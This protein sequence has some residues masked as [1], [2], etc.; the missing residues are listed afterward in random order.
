MMD[1]EII[2]LINGGARIYKYKSSLTRMESIK[3]FEITKEQF[4]QLENDIQ[5]LAE[6]ESSAQKGDH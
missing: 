2:N 3:S 1:Y 4:K 5:I 6:N